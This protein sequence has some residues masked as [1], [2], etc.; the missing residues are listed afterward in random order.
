MPP[1]RILHVFSTFDPGG[2]QVRTATII[3]ALG[4]KFSHAIIAMDGRFGA[5]DRIAPGADVQ[6]IDPPKKTSSVS[7][8]LALHDTLRRIGPD[9]LITYNW[10][11]IEALGAAIVGG[12]CPAVHAEDGFGPDEAQSLKSRRV[13]ARRV[14]LRGARLTVVPSRTLERIAL[15]RYKLPP[16]KVRFIPNGIDTARFR[17][18]LGREWRTQAGI[19]PGEILF[20]SVGHF[21]GEKN[22]EFL[23]RAFARAALAGSRL[24]L[25]GGGPARAAVEAA[26]REQ[27]LADRVI[28][29]GHLNDPLPFY[30]ALDVF[31]MSSLTEQMPIA[32]LEAMSCGLPA[33]C[34]DV[35][36]TRD[37]LNTSTPPQVIP[38]GDE[39][40]YAEALAAFA[41]HPSL[42]SSCGAANRDRCLRRYGLNRMLQE[43]EAL[44]SGHYNRP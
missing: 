30:S 31:V 17:P 32:L 33:V 43:Y 11:A 27:G 5:L 26:A 37:L 19:A 7:Y 9:L 35:G 1:P 6:R 8:P 3:N 40:V 13:L 44:Y 14:L 20:G 2:P 23:V 39:P 18:G 42:R 36:D 25:A 21:R 15:D 29:P 41:L 22:L 16:E 38:P 24:A 4:R 10:G 12:I 28:F 34:T